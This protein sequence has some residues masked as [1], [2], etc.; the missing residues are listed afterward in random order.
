MKSKL[1]GIVIPKN[2]KKDHILKAIEE[3]ERNQIPKGRRSKK[4]VLEH[5]HKHYPPKYIISLANKFANGEELSSGDF[6]G[7]KETNE[8]L[9]KL[10]FKITNKSLPDENAVSEVK[11]RK[12]KRI[13]SVH[14]E[15]CKDCKETIKK[16]LEKAY[17]VSESNYKFEVGTHPEDHK[18]S[19]YY[20]RIREIYEALQ[21]YRGFKGFVKVISLP[22]CDFFVPNPGFIL[23]FDESQHFT[24]PREITLFN[25]PAKLRLGFD[26]NKWIYL[27]RKLNRR[28][29]DPPYRDE[30]RAWYDTLRDFSVNFI[31][32]PV[33][34][35][36][37]QEHVWCELN[38][39][40]ERDVN[41]FKGF[42]EAK[43]ESISR[44]N[45]KK[46]VNDGMKIGL[47]FPELGEH[48]IK[49]FLGLMTREK[50]KLD[51]VIFPE[52]FETIS[53]E[54]QIEPNN[55]QNEE[56]IQSLINTYYEICQKLNLSI[57]VGIS[58]DYRDTSISGGGNDQYCLFITP[59][60]E[61]HIYHK[62][63]TSRYN[64]FFD[65]EWSIEG[66][67]PIFKIK[68][69]KIGFSICHDSYISLIPRILKTKGADIWV[70]IS[71]QNVRSW[72]WEPVHKTRALENKIIAL[73]TLHRNS[74]KKKNVQKEPYAFSEK[75]KI[76]LKDLMTNEYILEIPFE[77]R[78]GN[79]FYFSSSDY[80]TYPLE[81]IESSEMAK[82]AEPI[83]IKSNNE[84]K[85]DILGTNGK[86]LIR[87]ISLKEFIFSP[88]IIWNLFFENLNVVP[89][90]N[91]CVR[92]NKEWEKYESLAKRVIKGRVVEFSTLFIF[93]EIEKKNILLAAYR[94]SS[95]KNARIFY[96]DD[97]PLKIDKR[98]LMGIK[99]TLEIS[100]N[101][102]R[103]K[104]HHIYYRRINEI[105]KF[106][107]K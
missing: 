65:D 24:K 26:K 37:A 95:Y 107:L 54:N 4:F 1:G 76:K 106:L 71:Y 14:N 52:G 44:R 87:E 102:E 59:S 66:N 30:Q 51:L 5:N 72:I 53:A 34:R 86:F 43:L 74:N 27:C 83:E 29:N 63:S 2:I 28:D 7:G 48:D 20:C 61:K 58:I 94:S 49:H 17:G 99:S 45:A 105:I 84:G 77:E 38:E 100:L 57:I 85:L 12:I 64:A 88:E 8:F 79:V 35:V 42:I 68:D 73:C 9:E 23:E 39:N 15:R 97:F 11:Y 19:E 80:E 67:F 104:N 6:G 46:N 25:Y 70:N 90:F 31:K 16:M 92:N 22:R 96:P 33:I 91:I 10:R 60:G 50:N 62:H 82:K 69:K 81:K 41:W 93:R 101:D 36:F 13:K 3:T 55:V 18:D 32:Y 21:N 78:T 103:A 47:A 75:G 56:K 40:D 89:F 98:Y